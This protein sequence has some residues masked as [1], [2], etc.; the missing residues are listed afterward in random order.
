MTYQTVNDTVALDNSSKVDE[1][2]S[3]SRVGLWKKVAA[4]MVV[5]CALTY[6]ITRGGTRRGQ[7]NSLP[8][9]NL[10]GGLGFEQDVIGSAVGC[11]NLHDSCDKRNFGP[12][13]PNGCCSGL[14]CRQN[15]NTKEYFCYYTK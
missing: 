10:V 3:S 9:A 5:G 2:L 6:S 1:A 14:S 11:N 4:A 7:G 12:S 15:V 8:T 13:S